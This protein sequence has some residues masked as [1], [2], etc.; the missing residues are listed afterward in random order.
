MIKTFTKFLLSGILAT[1]LFAHDGVY[2][3]A[4]IAMKQNGFEYKYDKKQMES[5]LIS[6]EI[7][8]HTLSDGQ[9]NMSYVGTNKNMDIYVDDKRKLAAAISEVPDNEGVYALNIL[10]IDQNTTIIFGCIK[11][12][13]K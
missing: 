7:N 6:F 9:L 8:G 2:N 5:N 12:S 11:N 13:S 10:K 4:P 1:S 3:C